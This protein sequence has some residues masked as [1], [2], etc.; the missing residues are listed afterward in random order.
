MR[1]R[2]GF[3]KLQ[4]LFLGRH[5]WLEFARPAAAQGDCRCCSL[6]SWGR[7]HTPPPARISLGLAG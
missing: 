1:R 5:Q 3:S 2:P 7:I 6:T 4:Y